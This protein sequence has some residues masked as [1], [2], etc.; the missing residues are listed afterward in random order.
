[1]TKRTIA[2]LNKF[3]VKNN[4]LLRC[5]FGTQMCSYIVFQFFKYN[6]IDNLSIKLF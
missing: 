2:D 4:Y 1:M 3:S 6:I 5:H